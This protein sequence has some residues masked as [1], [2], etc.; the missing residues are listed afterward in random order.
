MRKS[1]SYFVL[2]GGFASVLAG[3][4][5]STTLAG[6]P[7]D[8]G[9]FNG[10]AV[11]VVAEGGI[12]ALR[13]THSVE[14]DSR[15]YVSV[16]RH[17]CTNDCQ[18]PMDSVA[19]TLAP[20]VTDSLFTIVLAQQPFSLRDDYGTTNGAAD[21][22]VY[23]VRI[24]AGGNVKTVRADDGTMPQPLRRIVDAVRGTLAAERQ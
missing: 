23:T 20:N 24:T 7:S 9:S 15:K 11:Q 2:A 1:I 22:M 19:G 14:H 3:C 21:M 5:A 17:I 8:F 13:I 4:G 18:A 6:L 12:A 16:Q 10:A